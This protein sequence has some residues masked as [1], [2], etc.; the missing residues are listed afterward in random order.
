MPSDTLLACLQAVLIVLEMLRL[1]GICSNCMPS[2][3]PKRV[4]DLCYETVDCD[5]VLE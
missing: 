5:F 4:K 1:Q 3:N 2:Q